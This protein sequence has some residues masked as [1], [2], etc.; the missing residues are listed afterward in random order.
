MAGRASRAW[1]TADDAGTRRGDGPQV[2]GSQSDD[3]R[4]CPRDVEPPGANGRRAVK[5]Q[6]GGSALTHLRRLTRS[7]R[8]PAPHR[9]LRS[10]RGM[11]SAPGVRGSSVGVVVAG[12]KLLAALR[13]VIE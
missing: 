11:G 2:T 9:A 13:A 1:P 7:P 5:G 12:Q 6:G 10:L 3:S 8:P 4:A